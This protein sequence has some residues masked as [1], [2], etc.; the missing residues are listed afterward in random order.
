MKNEVLLAQRW[1]AKSAWC[2]QN[3]KFSAKNGS[4]FIGHEHGRKVVL[5]NVN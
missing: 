4:A 5:N 3:G 1:C 2:V